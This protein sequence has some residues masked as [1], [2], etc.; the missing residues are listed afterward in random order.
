MIIFIF[1]EI[2]AGI[3]L[4]E[5]TSSAFEHCF[6]PEENIDQVD[7]AFELRKTTTLLGK[8]R[9]ESMS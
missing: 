9:K 3:D 4:S 2:D 7:L 1:L 8:Q 5:E 6:P